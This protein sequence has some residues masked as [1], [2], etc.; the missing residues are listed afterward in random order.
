MQLTDPSKLSLGG[1]LNERLQKAIRHLSDLNTEEMWRELENPDEIWHWG[2]DYP[3]RWI[4][5][6]ALFGSHT[7]EDYGARHAAKRLIG[8]QQPDGKFGTYTSPT[9]Y[10]EWF[11]MGRGLVGLI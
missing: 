4:A 11:G 6:M 10:K 8:Y 7:G 1:E 5:S 3:G 9:G 2:A